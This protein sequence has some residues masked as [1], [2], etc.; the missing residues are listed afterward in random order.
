MQK[1]NDFKQFKDLKIPTGKSVQF[2]LINI[3]DDKENPGRKI[4]PQT[5]VPFKDVIMI[6]GSIQEI[7]S[8]IGYN[9]KGEPIF[10]YEMMFKADNG[11]I[12]TLNS[13]T[14]L[15]EIRYPFLKLCNFNES[16]PNRDK[17]K[18]AIF[19]E[20]NPDKEVDD[21]V[22]KQELVIKAKNL[23][24]YL[25]E[26]EVKEIAAFFGFAPDRTPVLKNA[27]YGKCEKEPNEVLVKLEQAASETEDNVNLKNINQAF[28]RRKLTDD[29]VKTKVMFGDVEVFNYEHSQILD[30]SELVSYLEKEKP[31][32]LKSII[33]SIL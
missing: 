6:D 16:N 30:K 3:K 18:L 14:I 7:G 19:K 5:S 20:F 23:I 27:L 13:G 33:D 31:E 8:V 15:D 12:I 2:R 21:L 9:E 25:K 4:I 29:K 28:K 24:S 11:G 1:I 17:N 26:T 22:E 32:L 10:D